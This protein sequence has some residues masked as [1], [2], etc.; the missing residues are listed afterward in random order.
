MSFQVPAPPPS[1]ASPPTSG[2]APPGGPP[3][4]ALFHSA[5]AEELARTAPAEGLNQS[6]GDGETM[7]SHGASRSGSREAREEALAGE[8]A[9]TEASST[10]AGALVQGPTQ[11][12]R[13]MPADAVK[14]ASAA[15]S[16]RAA[17]PS[18]ISLSAPTDAA[19]PRSGAQSAAASQFAD[20]CST[21]AKQGTTEAGQGTTAPGQGTTEAGQ[22]TTAP[23]RGATAPGQSAASRPAEATQ[24]S[25]GA[26]TDAPG[27]PTAALDPTPILQSS[28]AASKTADVVA[29][30]ANTIAH[31]PRISHTPPTA[32]TAADARTS[33]AEAGKAAAQT[34]LR[35][36]PG[37]E[38]ALGRPARA[39][40]VQGRG[41]VRNESPAAP[42]SQSPKTSAQEAP[43]SAPAQSENTAGAAGTPAPRS[44]TGLDATIVR[45]GAV[46][47]LAVNAQPPASTVP[48]A[49]S[50]QPLT[51]K[52]EGASHLLAQGSLERAPSSVGTVSSTQ[53]TAPAQ[54]GEAPLPSTPAP[55]AQAFLAGQPTGVALQDMIES[56]HATV[57]LAARQGMAQARI[58]L[59]PAE[60][61]SVRI[62]LSQT[63][64]GLLARV[65]ADTPA[66]AQALASGHA[67][68]HQSLS[69]L[70]V[71]L[72]R[73][74]INS[75][76]QSEHRDSSGRS[77]GDRA[78]RSAPAAAAG[79]VAESEDSQPTGARQD[80]SPTG[81]SG[82]AL[83]D[84]LA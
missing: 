41:T 59:E 73:L 63:S 79:A 40:E 29:T 50:H 55:A 57:E 68:L 38:Q 76:G 19:K 27:A 66:A 18:T 20:G 1:T 26:S 35:N 37:L 2:A 61:G 48:G 62:H 28:G 10:T 34:A 46:P 82:G 81:L 14:T 15:G 65:S 11:P 24:P 54:Q 21:V 6:H 71:S 8:R 49:E 78:P 25:T 51:Q 47:A 56:I 39:A 31:T 84:V 44:A 60:L 23:G 13:E 12:V 16:S 22:G 17:T 53:P 5:F 33:S 69:S 52:R 70:G 4:E 64:D 77:T 67:E 9:A 72:L 83:V 80:L 58:A 42:V 30:N 43:A 45:E 32:P 36:A 74:D 3:G 75:F 7:P